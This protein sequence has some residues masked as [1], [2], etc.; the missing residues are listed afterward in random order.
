MR[1]Y[2]ITATMSWSTIAVAAAFMSYGFAH[3]SYA[4]AP[5]P[6]SHV[7]VEIVNWQDVTGK[8]TGQSPLGTSNVSGITIEDAAS[9][10]HENTRQAFANNAA[11]SNVEQICNNTNGRTFKAPIN[12]TVQALDQFQDMP[13]KWNRVVLYN[14]QCALVGGVSLF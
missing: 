3:S 7:C 1:K 12:V 4:Q 2:K 10:C 11:W 13:G 8:T 5:P 9:A 6:N 14:V